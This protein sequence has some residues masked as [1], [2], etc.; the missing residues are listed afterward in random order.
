MHEGSKKA[1][2]AALLGNAA[3]ALFKFSAAILSGSSSMLAEAYH[4]V[5]DSFNQVLLLYGI[6]RS[7]RPPDRLHPFGHGKEQFFWSFV[8]AIILFGI[9]GVL[10]VGEGLHK[11]RHPE[12]LALLWLNYAAI[13]V[14]FFFES[15]ALRIAVKSIKREM[16][17]EQHRTFIEAVRLS[18]NPI[19]MTVLFEDSLAL[20]GLCIAGAGIS[21]AHISGKP[22]FD[23]WASILIGVLLMVFALF[24]AAETK[25]LLVGEAVTQR[26]RAR[27][28]NCLESFPEV[29][30]VISLKTMHLGPEE[31]LVAVE[32]DY[33]DDLNL[34]CLE[35]LNDKI[36]E[37][38][39]EVVPDAKVYLE[40]ERM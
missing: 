39:R 6:K 11:L 35:S 1:V 16:R 17:R 4:S 24:L 20:V 15:L 19:T 8:V 30:K 32:I 29:E 26:N 10:S 2:I 37:M 25:A 34:E 5:S 28:L 13:A 31:V 14:A 21:V 12:P 9:A 38:I 36:E 18:K 22:F 7:K 3:I 23:A 33:R 40:P 27:I